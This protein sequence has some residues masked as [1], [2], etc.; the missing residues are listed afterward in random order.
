[1]VI[2]KF[3]NENL[4]IKEG[5]EIV[6]SIEKIFEVIFIRVMKKDVDIVIVFLNMVVIVYNKILLY[7]IVGIV[8]MGLF[9]LVLIEN[10]KDYF[11][12]VGKEVGCIGKGFILDII[13]KSFLL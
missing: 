5:Y 7:N 8:G 4:E 12:L 1:M 10:I 6:Y 9:Y 11:D 2:V 13:I 3:V